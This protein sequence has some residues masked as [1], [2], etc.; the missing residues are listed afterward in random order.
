M[1]HFIPKSVVKSYVFKRSLLIVLQRKGNDFQT[2]EAASMTNLLPLPPI[3]MTKVLPFP[4]HLSM[5]KLLPFPCRTM[6]KLLPFPCRSM[7]K[8]YENIF[9]GLISFNRSPQLKKCIIWDIL[10]FTPFFT[11][12]NIVFHYCSNVWSSFLVFPT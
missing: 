6:S 8:E 12:L 5:T 4:L 1:Q 10:V 3:S 7:S 9:R 2:V 11:S